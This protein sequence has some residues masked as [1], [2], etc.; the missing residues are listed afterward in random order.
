MFLNDYVYN[1]FD[2]KQKRKPRPFVQLKARKKRMLISFD[3]RQDTGSGQSDSQVEEIFRS[4]QTCSRQEN[5][6]SRSE[7]DRA[8]LPLVFENA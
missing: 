4:Y 2:C 7:S 8:E 6:V 3:D 1:D 5:T